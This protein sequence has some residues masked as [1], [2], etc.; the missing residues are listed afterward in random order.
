MEIEP[1]F[2]MCSHRVSEDQQLIRITCDR[3]LLT[4]P[5]RLLIAIVDSDPIGW[6]QSR[7]VTCALII[8]LKIDF[9]LEKSIFNSR[10]SLEIH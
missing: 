8:N 2:A 1:D 3:T 9:K 10:N 6:L 4:M 7:H 5:R